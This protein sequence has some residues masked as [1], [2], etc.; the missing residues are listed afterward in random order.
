[1]TTD[2]IQLLSTFSVFNRWGQKV[3]ETRSQ[4]EGW[5]GTVNGTP[6]DM[7]IYYYYLRYKCN[8]NMIEK[9]GEITLIR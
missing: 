4:Y 2:G 8:E 9:K 6:Q 1:M 5:D 7:G 3:F